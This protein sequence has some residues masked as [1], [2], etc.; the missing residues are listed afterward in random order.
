MFRFVIIRC[1]SFERYKTVRLADDDDDDDD[2]DDNNNNNNNNN[3]FNCDFTLN[4]HSSWKNPLIKI[5][6][7]WRS[8]PFYA[9][10][11]GSFILL[12]HLLPIRN[13]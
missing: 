3:N 9:L 8:P 5:F 6:S 7:C 10:F 11:N 12:R 1:R 4:A 2:D 13:F